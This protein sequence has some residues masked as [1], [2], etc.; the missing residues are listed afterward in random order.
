MPTSKKKIIIPVA[1][2]LTLFLV[3]IGIY[4][5]INNQ[6]QDTS[7]MPSPQ[8]SQSSMPVSSRTTSSSTTTTVQIQN[9]NISITLNSPI[10]GQVFTDTITIRTVVSGTNNGTCTARFTNDNGQV[11]TYEAEI[12]QAATYFA[13]GGFDVPQTDFETKGDW[14]V[15]VIVNSV[16]GSSKSATRR[17]SIQ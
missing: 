16:D 14:M 1:L 10:D 12:V 3:A 11:K 7:P 15:Q 9:P 4:L 17:I 5:K 8:S 13:C 2:V 6:P